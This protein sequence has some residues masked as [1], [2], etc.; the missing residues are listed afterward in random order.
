M[1]CEAG[2][3]LVVH[4]AKQ[5]AYEV[6]IALQ[7]SE[8]L[9]QFVTGIYD[10]RGSWFAT[11]ARTASKVWARDNIER[12]LSKRRHE[13]L[14]PNKVTTWPAAELASRLIGRTSLIQR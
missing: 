1:R 2:D 13:A 8:R 12:L 3:V 4:P 6:A 14:E 9:L 5:H 10:H 11:V 7:Q